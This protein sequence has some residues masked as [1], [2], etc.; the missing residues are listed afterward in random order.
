M[1]FILFLLITRI[2]IKDFYIQYISFPSSIGAERSNLFEIQSILLSL[3]N[4]FKFI[5]I[6]TLIIFFKLLIEKKK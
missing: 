6:F 5:S 4:E 2:G 3:I 1:A